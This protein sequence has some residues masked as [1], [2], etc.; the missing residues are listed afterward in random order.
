MGWRVFVPLSAELGVDVDFESIDLFQG[1]NFNPK[2][3][4]NVSRDLIISLPIITTPFFRTR[5]EPCPPLSIMEN[6][7]PAP[8]R[9]LTI[10]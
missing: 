5:R 8:P 1:E 2:F 3:L 9:W 10:S 4:A 7:T 6:R